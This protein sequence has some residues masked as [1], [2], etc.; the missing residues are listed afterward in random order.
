MSLQKHPSADNTY[1]TERLILRPMSGEDKDFIFELYN[2][3]K[4]VQYIGN[5]NVNSTE[6]AENYIL[7]RFAPQIERLGYGNYLLVTKDSNEK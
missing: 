2:R 5:R 3:P 1:E 7:N 6:D 4:F